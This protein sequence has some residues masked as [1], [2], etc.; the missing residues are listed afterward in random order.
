MMPKNPEDLMDRISGDYKSFFEWLVSRSKT[1]LVDDVMY[2][3]HYPKQYPVW[4]PNQ[5]KTEFVDVPGRGWNTFKKQSKEMSKL[6]AIPDVFSCSG[7]VPRVFLSWW[8]FLASFV[9]VGVPGVSYM[10]LEFE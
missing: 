8:E 6:E 1:L 3:K 10:F 2:S 7:G 9:L 4:C 5:K